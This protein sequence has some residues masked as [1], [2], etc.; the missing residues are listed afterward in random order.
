MPYDLHSDE[1]WVSDDWTFG[2]VP[3][4][5]R[6][7]ANKKW[8][9]VGLHDEHLTLCSCLLPEYEQVAR[10]SEEMAKLQHDAKL[11]A[12]HKVAMT[13]LLKHRIFDNI[14][15]CPESSEE[16]RCI[17]Y[18][19]VEAKLDKKF[20]NHKYQK[21]MKNSMA[22][23][24][25]S[26]RRQP[27]HNDSGLKAVSDP[28]D[29]KLLVQ[30]LKFSGT[31]SAQKIFD[32]HHRESIQ[33]RA[34]ELLETGQ[35]AA[36]NPGGTDQH[37]LK[38]LWEEA[39]EEERERCKQMALEA[40]QDVDTH[41]K[42]LPGLMYQLLQQ[43]NHF[44]GPAAFMFA[45]ACRNAQGMIDSGCINVSWDDSHKIQDGLAPNFL[46]QVSE[47]AD[48]NLPG[49]LEQQLVNEFSRNLSGIVFFPHINLN[50]TRVDQVQTLLDEYFYSLWH[51]LQPVLSMPPKANLGLCASTCSQGHATSSYLVWSGLPLMTAAPKDMDPIKTLVLAKFLQ[52]HSNDSAREPF[53]FYN[54][55]APSLPSAPA[56]A[57]CDQEMAE[58]LTVKATS[59]KENLPATVRTTQG[60]QSKQ[61]KV[62]KEPASDRVVNP[63]SINQEV[64]RGA[65]QRTQS[66]WTAAA[67]QIGWSPVK[68][69]GGKRSQ[70]V[71][72]EEDG[73]QAPKRQR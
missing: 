5:D 9:E 50:S 43:L 30:L 67:N 53:C 40:I 45:F 8:K 23:G 15:C 35:V 42:E 1:P 72:I 18:V 26:S 13:A 41:H 64:R 32:D 62:A 34:K 58:A 63:V 56:K 73:A 29:L 71:L 65:R 70:N 19:S 21:V 14:V 44:L 27:N 60:K 20:H 39:S 51:K 47:W 3:L 36:R 55:V 61:G 52:E 59:A 28:K 69:T 10:D 17:A 66:T 33:T 4:Q 31:I 16:E 37:A 68:S 54:A 24:Q 48:I 38:Q 7:H 11:R 57:I 12:W 22:S 2:T 6:V 49:L 25:S 46:N